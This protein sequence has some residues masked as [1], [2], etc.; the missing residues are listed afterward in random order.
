M[1]TKEILQFIGWPVMILLSYFIASWA[2][3]F[4]EKK[5]SQEEENKD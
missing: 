1:Y 4:Y 2:V 5:Y 3:K